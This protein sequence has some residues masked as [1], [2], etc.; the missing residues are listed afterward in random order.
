MK[1]VVDAKIWQSLCMILAKMKEKVKFKFAKPGLEIRTL[2]SSHTVLLDWLLPK[3]VFEQYETAPEI[4]LDVQEAKRYLRS[5]GSKDKVVISADLES[6]SKLQLGV[7]G[8]HGFRRFGLAVMSPTEEDAD[9]PKVKSFVADVKAKISVPAFAEAYADAKVVAGDIGD[10]TLEA[11]SKPERFVIWATEEGTFRS[12]WYEF[13]PDISLLEMECTGDKV[14]A[15]YGVAQ[16]AIVLLGKAFSN[17]ML[18]E[19]AE[20]FPARFTYQL[21]F[22]GRLQFWVAPRV[23]KGGK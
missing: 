12:S 9:P 20:D 16:L 3:E 21:A 22:P 13:T 19:Y 10:L 23:Y 18:V 6:E 4:V 17:I 11:R 8:R 7:R 15:H 1:A 14:R 2:D 5:I